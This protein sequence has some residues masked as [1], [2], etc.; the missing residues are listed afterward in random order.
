M[1][2][3]PSGKPDYLVEAAL[4]HTSA[5]KVWEAL[6]ERERL[7]IAASQASAGEARATAKAAGVPAVKL[8]KAT[9]V[10]ALPP[11]PK[12]LALEG[13]APPPHAA[14]TAPLEP[15]APA[16]VRKS[17]LASQAKPKAQ[18]QVPDAAAP[19]KGGRRSSH[20]RTQPPSQYDYETSVYYT[21][22]SEAPK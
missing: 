11:V 9:A 15:L 8:V 4:A 19:K 2:L 3:Q 20:V 5:A 14:G 17:S 10:R 12:V 13:A 18:V 1:A 21:S 7:A 22:E 6:A 16:A